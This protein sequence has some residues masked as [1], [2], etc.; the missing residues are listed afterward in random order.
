M[1]KRGVWRMTLVHFAAQIYT[2]VAY[3]VVYL[4]SV[5]VD[6]RRGPILGD[7]FPLNGIG[8]QFVENGCGVDMG[9]RDDGDWLRFGIF[10]PY[11]GTR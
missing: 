6:A 7:A 2:V 9:L 11:V 1:G 5:Q 10:C 8:C 3:R 4:V